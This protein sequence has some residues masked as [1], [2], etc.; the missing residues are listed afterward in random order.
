MLS[1]EWRCSWSSADR[2]CSNYIWVINNSIAYQ[3]RFILE[4]WQ[5]FEIMFFVYTCLTSSL[6][7][8]YIFENILLFFRPCRRRSTFETQAEYRDFIRDKYGLDIDLYLREIEETNCELQRQEAEKQ[9]ENQRNS[10][11]RRGFKYILTETIRPFRKLLRRNRRKLH[12]KSAKWYGNNPYFLV[13]FLSN[14]MNKIYVYRVSCV[15]P[16][17]YR[18][19]GLLNKMHVRI[20]VS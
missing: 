12:E 5:Y 4:G 2:R 10:S 16:S 9:M 6:C 15:I 18:G 20:R 1:R 19:Y 13:L 11:H 3:V 7:S 14:F 17:I 8:T